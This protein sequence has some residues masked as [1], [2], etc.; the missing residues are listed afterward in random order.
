MRKNYLSLL[1]FFVAMFMIF[2]SLTARADAIW[3]P[4]G[5]FYEQHWEECE[6]INESYLTNGEEGFVTVYESPL[7]GKEV[8]KIKNGKAVYIGCVW[9]D[10]KGNLWGAVDL[11]S[12]KQEEG[13]TVREEVYN[14][15]APMENFAEIYNEG[16]FRAEHRNEF[17]EYAGELDDYEI[18][19][20]IM[21]W[22]YPGSEELPST[23]PEYWNENEVPAYEYLYT[24]RDGLRWTYIGYYYGMKG[25]VCVDDPENENLKTSYGPGKK[26]QE[27]YPVN[28]PDGE[29]QMTLK[30]PAD[31][32]LKA[33]LIA[34]AAVVLVTVI[35][36]P[37]I[38]GK[39]R[40]KR[41]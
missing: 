20:E 19:N 22:T 9:N 41:E 32:S 13:E 2:P 4:F 23:L 34:V 38:F 33:V 7:S 21:I 35:L 18:K 37:V 1:I 26:E 40:G 30:N 39:K 27:L 17:K 24:D 14:G 3:E 16:D 28:T 5:D 36:I 6:P 11:H 10:R 12:F 15:W 25:W 31:G 8:A 29:L